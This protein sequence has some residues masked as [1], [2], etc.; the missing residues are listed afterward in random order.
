MDRAA[1]TV[2]GDA[3]INLRD[4]NAMGS[5]LWYGDMRILGPDRR[6]IDIRLISGTMSAV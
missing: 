4:V 3:R 1:E 2:S 6:A 5:R